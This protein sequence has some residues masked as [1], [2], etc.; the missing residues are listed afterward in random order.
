MGFHVP[1]PADLAK[2]VLHEVEGPAKQLVDNAASAAKSEIESLAKK[3][4]LELE[5]EAEKGLH[6]LES[7]AEKAVHSVMEKAATEAASKAIKTAAAIARD[8]HDQNV[9][10]DLQVQLSFVT[11][12]L[13]NVVDHL[14]TLEQWAE[15]PPSSLDDIKKIVTELE[16]DQ[17]SFS[18]QIGLSLVVID[19]GDLD[20]GVT[21][22]VHKKAFQAAWNIFVNRLNSLL[23]A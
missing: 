10:F 12:E 19:S 21:M 3:G 20:F 8:M 7:A 11:F 15:H 22:T 18:L 23:A 9:D 16:P 13:D 5:S 6:E 17:V 2:K 14:A 1:N 4:L